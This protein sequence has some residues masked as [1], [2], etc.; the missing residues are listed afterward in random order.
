VVLLDPG[1]KP[2]KKITLDLAT[3]GA[4]RIDDG[5]PRIL[6]LLRL[7]ERPQELARCFADLK[8]AHGRFVQ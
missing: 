6:R 1:S 5:L 3:D 2:E 8:E 4:E 7:H